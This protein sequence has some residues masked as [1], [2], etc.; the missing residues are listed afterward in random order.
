[1]LRADLW[2]RRFGGDP[3]V[4]G[5][6]VAQVRALWERVPLFGI[7][8]GHQLLGLAA[9]AETFKLPYGHRGSNHPV[10]D[11]HTGHVCVTTQNHGYAVNEASL[12]RSEMVVTHR[13]LNDGTVEGLRH[14]RLPIVSVQYHPEGRPGPQD[15]AY[16]FDQWMT[17]VDGT[18]TSR[19]AAAAPAGSRG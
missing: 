1:V 11:L 16:L 2:K 15:S 7:C 17:V 8:L 13:N 3:Q 6:Q 12:E 9:G 5:F 18:P 10:K 4:L 19:A 14:R